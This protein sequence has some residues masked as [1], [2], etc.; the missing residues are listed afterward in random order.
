MYLYKMPFLSEKKLI[1]HTR[2]DRRIKLTERQKNA[3]LKQYGSGASIRKLSRTYKVDRKTIKAVLNPEWYS[4]QLLKQRK[5]YLKYPP[6]TEEIIIRQ[7][8]HRAYKQLL[9]VK[10]LI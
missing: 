10:K 3:I 4:K 9:H 7:K 5:N 2:Y 8:E 6:T 1:N